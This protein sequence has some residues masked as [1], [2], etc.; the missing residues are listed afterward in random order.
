MKMNFLAVGSTSISDIFG[1]I[2]PPPGSPVGDATV[3]VAKFVGVTIQL[4]LLIAGLLLLVYLFL[5]ALDWL[6]SNGEKERVAKAQNKIVAALVGFFFLIASFVLFQVVT[7]GVL[8]GRFIQ[9]QN[10]QWRILF[11]TIAP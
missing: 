7:Q 1:G 5:G 11:P 4:M 8:G 9:I 6:T 10:G 2:S 3:G